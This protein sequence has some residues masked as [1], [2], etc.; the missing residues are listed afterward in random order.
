MVE[1]E[2]GFLKISVHAWTSFLF[3]LKR[4]VIRNAK[5]LIVQTSR[6]LL[7][8]LD[9]PNVSRTNYS[10]INQ[11]IVLHSR[12]ES[13]L[14]IVVGQINFSYSAVMI[15]FDLENPII[16]MHYVEDD[17]CAHLEPIET[18]MRTQI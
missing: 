16:H 7:K 1:G 17:Q 6:S 9:C 11:I 18:W 8:I 4:V 15:H 2:T 3:L 10:P 14:V 12:T 13:L 5:M